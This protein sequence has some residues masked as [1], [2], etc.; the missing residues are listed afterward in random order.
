[1]AKAQEMGAVDY[2]HKPINKAELLEK[3]AKLI[4]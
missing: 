2:I 1:M 3:V 4:K